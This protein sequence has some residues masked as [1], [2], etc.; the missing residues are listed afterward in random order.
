MQ[1]KVK[2]LNIYPTI[3]GKQEELIVF[4]ESPT[5][6]ELIDKLC[7]IYEKEFRE[8][9]L[10]RENKLKPHAWILV[11]GLSVKELDMKLKD[12]ELVVFSLPVAGG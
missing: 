11:D 12:G 6:K 10:D 4:S 1:I 5:L 2:Y 8:A 3:T 9:V 7:T